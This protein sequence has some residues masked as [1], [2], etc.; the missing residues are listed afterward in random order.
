R[1]ELRESRTR[2]AR[3]KRRS[4]APLS[5]HEPQRAGIGE[6]DLRGTHVGVAE[7]PLNAPDTRI[8]LRSNGNA[9]GHR[10]DEH[11][12]SGEARPPY[13]QVVVHT[14]MRRAAVHIVWRILRPV[15]LAFSHYQ[16]YGQRPYSPS[17]MDTQ[18]DTW[19]FT[20]DSR[21]RAFRGA[22]SGACQF[23]QVREAG[24]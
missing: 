16:G 23:N 5:G 17:V 1:T 11:E 4:R 9:D 10:G 19:R 15:V 20:P 2:R 14:R 13:E 22:E 21:Q 6:D 3:R 24:L 8:L 12:G 7:E 18:V